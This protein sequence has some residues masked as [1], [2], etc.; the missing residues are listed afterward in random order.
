MGLRQLD[1]T[2]VRGHYDAR[3][4]AHERL[5]ALRESGDLAGFASLLL[6]VSDPVGNYSAAEHGLG[7]RI[8]SENGP[9]ALTRIANLATAL[10]AVQKTSEVPRHI[11][12]AQIK[13]LGIGVGSEASCMLKP[14]TCWVA[15][16]R[17]IWAHLLVKHADN[18]ERANEELK[19]YRSGE[20]S[21]MDYAIWT[22]IHRLLETS[23]TR[24]AEEGA[25]LAREH[26]VQPGELAYL[27]ADAIANELYSVLHT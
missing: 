26:G 20:P 18:V 27:W 11:K 2:A 17:S 13:Y 12:A 21:E 8:L 6:G 24:I 23:M 5:L 14:R 4:V 16:T 19:L 10:L 3:I 25:R 9:N 1:W 15:N 7:P 22:E